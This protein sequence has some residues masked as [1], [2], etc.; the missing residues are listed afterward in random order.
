MASSNL[1]T[2][3]QALALIDGAH[4]NRMKVAALRAE[5][6]DAL[7]EKRA[8]FDLNSIGETLSQGWNQASGAV[9]D[10]WNNNPNWQPALLGAG[11]GAGA[12]LLGG[13]LTK[14]KRPFRAAL[15]GGLLGGAGGGL[16]SLLQ[17]ATSASGDGLGKDP[18]A[19]RLRNNAAAIANAE[20]VVQDETPGGS[21]LDAAAAVVPTEIRW[22]SSGPRPQFGPNA[23]WT[24]GGGATGFGAGMAA[25]RAVRSVSSVPDYIRNMAKKSP[26]DTE[27]QLVSNYFRDHPIKSRLSA[28]FARGPS[29]GAGQVLA[30]SGDDISAELINRVLGLGKIPGANHSLADQMRLGLARTDDAYRSA[31]ERASTMLTSAQKAQ[32]TSLEQLANSLRQDARRA[33]S[34]NNHAFDQFVDDALAGLRNEVGHLNS[35]SNQDLL[36]RIRGMID[37]ERQSAGLVN[38]TPEVRA[39]LLAISNQTTGSDQLQQAITPGSRK[40]GILAQLWRNDSTRPDRPV[41]IPTTAPGIRNNLTR[42]GFRSAVQN[43]KWEIPRG[44]FAARSLLPLTMGAGGAY[45]GLL[46]SITPQQQQAQESAY[47]AALNNLTRLQQERAALQQQISGGTGQ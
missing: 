44:S 15:L 18:P 39:R 23:G 19:I 41:S 47:M 45:A 25:N 10:A 30:S 24:A 40:P 20:Q 35:V 9:T 3:E 26:T 1:P 36:N 42:G 46:R 31:L 16:Y 22:T 6:S 28:M 14:K 8:A 21:L 27:A 4:G 32:G 38:M 11:L 12:G 43:A 37:Q 33:L 34:S 29:T 5:W 7:R 13:M 2:Y 17:N